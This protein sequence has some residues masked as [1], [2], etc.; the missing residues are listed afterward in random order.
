[1]GL[2]RINPL[3][4]LSRICLSRARPAQC[5]AGAVQL[6]VR[7]ATF[8]SPFLSN[9]TLRC[10]RW[11]FV[12]VFICAPTSRKMVRKGWTVLERL[13]EA[14]DSWTTTIGPVAQSRAQ[15][16]ADSLWSGPR[17]I[18]LQPA[19]CSRSPTTMITGGAAPSPNVGSCIANVGRRGHTQGQGGPG[20]LKEARV[21][22]QGLPLGV[23]FCKMRET[24]CRVGQ[25]RLNEVAHM[26]E[27]KANLERLRQD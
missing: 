11:Q 25:E 20:A 14:T 5:A 19:R 6:A 7:T 23:Q 15:G 10:R 2:T 16:R 3:A 4:G 9:G 21:T 13:V 22:A 27:W 17:A 8:K 12:S 24:H 26:A 1:M 18:A